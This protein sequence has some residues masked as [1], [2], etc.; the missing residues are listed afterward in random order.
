M[1]KKSIVILLVCLLIVSISAGACAKAPA[2]EA[3]EKSLTLAVSATYTGGLGATGEHVCDGKIDYLHWI[4]S[5]GGIEY[6]DPTSGQTETVAINVIWED[7][8]YDVAKATSAYKRMR[9][10]GANAILGFGSTPGEACAAHAS[11][12]KIPYLSWYAYAS[13]AGYDPKPQY[14]WTCLP[15]IA[16]SSTA[17]AKWLVKEKLQGIQTPK[18]GYMALDVPSWRPLTKPGI[19]A[20]Y[21][22]SIGG[23]LVGIEWMPPLVTDLSVQITRLVTEKK[24]QGIVL[25]GTLDQAIVAAKDMSRLGIDPNE[26]PLVCNPSAWD[27]SLLQFREIE[28]LYG[29]T[30]CALPGADVPGMALVYQVAESAGRS[31]DELLVNYI[32]GLIGAQ[33]FAEGVKRALEN[34][35]YDSVASSGEAIRHVLANFKRLDTGGLAEI[36]MRYPDIEPF[37]LSGSRITQAKGG[38]FV[39]VSD[40]IE[41]DLIK[42]ALD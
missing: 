25:I 29:E 34:E 40:V 33:A 32:A 5:Q 3:P 6:K 41:L 7:N 22:E 37:F 30:I 11:R 26:F 4:A 16:E 39:L 20:P 2:P 35:G 10:A 8:Q 9:A 21:I 14:Y 31:P 18:I 23:E 38:K 42:G 19:M 36:E 17:M 1:G 28:G 24:A 27:E 13:P 15:S 12:D